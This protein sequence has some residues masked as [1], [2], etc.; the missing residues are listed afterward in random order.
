MGRS[1]S[2]R[3]REENG[4]SPIDPNSPLGQV[5]IQWDEDYLR[6]FTRSLMKVTMINFCR[7]IWPKYPIGPEGAYTWDPEGETDRYWMTQLKNY[8]ILNKKEKEKP[9]LEVW[10][11][12]RF[13]GPDPPPV[14]QFPLRKK[15]EDSDEETRPAPSAPPVVAQRSPSPPAHPAVTSPPGNARLERGQTSPGNQD[16]GEGVS[17]KEPNQEICSPPPYQPPSREVQQLERDIQNLPFPEGKPR[18]S[19]LVEAFRKYRGREGWGLSRT[20]DPG[21]SPVHTFPLRETPG[22]INA[23]GNPVMVYVVSPI[24]PSE[25]RE[26]KQTLPK[27]HEN[28]QEVANLLQMWMGP[29]IYTYT[30]LMYILG[31]L[32]TPE[33]KA[34]IRRAAMQYWEVKED[35]RVAAPVPGQGAQQVVPSETKFPLGDPNWDIND[36]NHRTH[37]IDLKEMILEGIR[38]AVPQ[39]TNLTKAFEVNQMKEESPGDFIQRIRDHLTKYSGVAPD[40]PAFDNLLKMQFVTK[41]WPDIQ[42][43]LQ[44]MNWQDAAIIDLVRT[45]QQVYVNREAVKVSRSA[46]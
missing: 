34:M 33:E 16:A 35:Q 15:E 30:E 32:F 41:A 46:R 40:S 2:K 17:G 11:H 5:L 9:Y 20:E 13:Y 25:L 7:N 31:H 44:K 3:Q 37:L 43:K 22:G 36:A 23:H 14:S 28:S 1:Q 38:R 6:K 27:L 4:K 39:S 26:L 8:L 29:H 45:A 21:D 18:G 10:F 12:A 19:P 24:K 42:K